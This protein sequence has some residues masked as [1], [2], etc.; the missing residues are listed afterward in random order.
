MSSVKTEEDQEITA[1]ESVKDEVL[2]LED[3]P[4]KKEDEGKTKEEDDV[5]AKEEDDVKAKEED[6][7]KAKKEDAIVEK[8]EIDSLTTR[9]SDKLSGGVKVFREALNSFAGNQDEDITVYHVMDKSK[10]VTCY[11]GVDEAGRGPV[12][13][14]FSMPFSFS[15]VILLSKF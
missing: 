6:D 11:L 2:D 14:N 7:V 4:L 1:V 9:E 15:K 10:E 13:G 5:K 12:L 3:E 8:E